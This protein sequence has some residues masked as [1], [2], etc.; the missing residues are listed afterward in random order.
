MA[1][2]CLS[3]YAFPTLGN[4]NAVPSRVYRQGNTL[5]PRFRH[6]LCAKIGRR[7]RSDFRYD[8]RAKVIFYA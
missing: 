5:G 6:W 1:G 8:A 2:P 3:N 4:L 7:F